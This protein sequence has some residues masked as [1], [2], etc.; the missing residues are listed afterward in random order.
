M[1]E[2]SETAKTTRIGSMLVASVFV[3]FIGSVTILGALASYFNKGGKGR[4]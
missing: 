1:T 3:G 4:G 2:E